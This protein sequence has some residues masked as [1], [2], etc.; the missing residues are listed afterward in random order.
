MARSTCSSSV[1]LGSGDLT[2]DGYFESEP[3]IAW[4]RTNPR[5]MGGDP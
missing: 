3:E 2:I 1:G 4:I 5:V